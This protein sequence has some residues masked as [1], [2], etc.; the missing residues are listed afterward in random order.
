M[1]CP[2]W[3]A[4]GSPLD[5]SELGHLAKYG[6]I[7]LGEICLCSLTNL[8]VATSL[9]HFGCSDILYGFSHLGF[10]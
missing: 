6:R 7:W 9:T 4:W 5:L 2:T 1:G 8:K 3:L 10:F